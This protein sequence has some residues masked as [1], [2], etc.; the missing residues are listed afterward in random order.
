MRPNEQESNVW[1]EPGGGRGGGRTLHLLDDRS[2]ERAAVPFREQRG[3]IHCKK[4]NSKSNMIMF[5]SPLIGP[6]F[7]VGFCSASLQWR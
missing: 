3:E 5:L 7:E 6:G 2:E 4:R 1:H